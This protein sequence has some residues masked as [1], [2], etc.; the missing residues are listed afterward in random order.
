[1]SQAQ[2]EEKKQARLDAQFE[3]QAAA[4]YLYRKKPIA[5]FV[6]NAFAKKKKGA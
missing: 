6:A 5:V 3:R 1:M 4:E 2:R